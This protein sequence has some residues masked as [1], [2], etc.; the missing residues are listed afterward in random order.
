MVRFD[1][2]VLAVLRTE[3]PCGTWVRYNDVMSR[4]RHRPAL[5]ARVLVCVLATRFMWRPSSPKIGRLIDRDHSTVLHALKIF[6]SQNH[7]YERAYELL[8]SELCRLEF[9]KQQSRQRAILTMQE[10]A[11]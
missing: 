2:I 1:Q 9:S 7:Y 8:K 3:M 6:K 10:V 4:S 5:E 11:A